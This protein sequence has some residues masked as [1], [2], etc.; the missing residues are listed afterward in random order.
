MAPCQRSIWGK[1]FNLLS[2]VVSLF[3]SF[4]VKISLADGVWP[5]LQGCDGSDWERGSFLCVFKAMA[6]VSQ[7]R[8]LFLFLKEKKMRFDFPSS[9]WH[10]DLRSR[11][12]KERTLCVFIWRCVGTSKSLSLKDHSWSHLPHVLWITD[13]FCINKAGV[14]VG[15]CHWAW[16]DII[17][18]SLLRALWHTETRST[19]RAM[20]TANKNRTDITAGREEGRG[21]RSGQDFDLC[22]VWWGIRSVTLVWSGC[23]V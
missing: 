9:P 14:F 5:D 4:K 8:I 21:A 11:E 3:L 12:V 23:L 7:V 1:N 13:Y 20:T 2:L 16:T 10:T 17:L 6:H 19:A 18:G 22:Q 15:V